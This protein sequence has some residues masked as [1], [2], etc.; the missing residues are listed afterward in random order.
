MNISL[1]ELRAELDHIF[2]HREEALKLCRNLIQTSSKCIRNIHRRDFKAA[3]SL[4]SEAIEIRARAEQTLR[5]QPTIYFAGYLQ[6][7]EKEL[8]EAATLLGMIDPERAIPSAQELK[9]GVVSYLHGIGEAAS[10]C[11]RYLLDDLRK[12]RSQDAERLF[13][14]MEQIY[15]DLITFDY[16]DGMTSG[17]RRTCDALRAVIERTRSDL[18]LTT[19]QSQLQRDLES[20]RSRLETK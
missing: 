3:H 17:L 8:V 14:I 16:P 18:T 15:D 4:L 1:E 10:E 7:A 11:R 9:V 5:E 12:G 6:D 19:L 13:E 2:H 20:T